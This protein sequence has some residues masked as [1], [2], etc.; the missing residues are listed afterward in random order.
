MYVRRNPEIVAQRRNRPGVVQMT[1]GDQD[2]RRPQP[3]FTD[4]LHQAVD[5]VLAGVDDQAGIT[6]IIGNDE[7]IGA[8]GTRREASHNHPGSLVADMPLNTLRR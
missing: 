3:V 6:W 8:E 7:A 5:G 2:S 4:D 1:M